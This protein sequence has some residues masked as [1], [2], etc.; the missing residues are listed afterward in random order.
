[1][2]DRHL[3]GTTAHAT[4]LQA[5]EAYLI[6]LF[7]DANLVGIHAKRTSI[8]PKASRWKPRDDAYRGRV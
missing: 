4:V 1:M 2:S 6:G 8:M 5:A 7:E 3:S